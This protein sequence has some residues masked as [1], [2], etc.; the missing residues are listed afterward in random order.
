MLLVASAASVSG[1]TQFDAGAV[2]YSNILGGPNNPGDA[3]GLA[4]LQ[5][6]L[7]RA[8]ASHQLSRFNIDDIF[9]R[10]PRR[11]LIRSCKLL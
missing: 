8:V 1:R 3:D 4:A 10:L 2:A 5:V 6:C 9:L 11:A 7:L